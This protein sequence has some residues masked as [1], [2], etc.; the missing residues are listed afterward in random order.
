M[1]G[2]FK[3]RGARNRILQLSAAERAAGVIAA[4]AGN[5]A[6]GLSFHAQLEGVKATIVMPTAT[7]LI[8]VTATRSYGAH[9]V[10]HGDSY[11][12]AAA[13]ALRLQRE[14]G[15]TLVPAFDDPAVIA[16]QGSIGLEILEQVPDVQAVV[17]PVGGGGLI[18]GIAVAIKEQKPG[19][20]VYGV[21]AELVPS[22]LRALQSGQP[23]LVEPRRTIAEGIGARRAGD[24]PFELA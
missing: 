8:K 9:V 6:Q 7:A 21:E 20:K 24:H 1:T 13:E 5:H 19:V 14:C 12:D 4:S 22:M 15:M 2:S 23:V 17:V 16:G 3:E 11:D 18:G 10:L